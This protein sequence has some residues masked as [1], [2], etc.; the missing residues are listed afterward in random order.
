MRIHL[1]CSTTHGRAKLVPH[2]IPKFHQI[3]TSTASTKTK[4]DKKFFL[5]FRPDMKKS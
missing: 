3:F 4:T 1:G 5:R 2:C